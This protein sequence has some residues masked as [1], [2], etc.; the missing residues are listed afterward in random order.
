MTFWQILYSTSLTKM[1]RNKQRT[2]TSEEVISKERD[3]LCMLDIFENIKIIPNRDNILRV[4]LNK[5]V[6]TKILLMKSWSIKRRWKAFK[7]I[8]DVLW[9]I[10]RSVS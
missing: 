10:K 4:M 3:L 6:I 7:V 1:D 9:C 2:N 8:C 5:M